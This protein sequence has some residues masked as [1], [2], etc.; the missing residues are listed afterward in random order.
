MLISN[1]NRNSS[2]NSFIS[3]SDVL[4]VQARDAIKSQHG[5][6]NFSP[7]VWK[8]IDK[9]FD[10]GSS[11]KMNLSDFNSEERDQYLKIIATL[12]KKGIIGWNY[13]EVNG[14]IEKHFTDTSIGDQR[15]ANAVPVKWKKPD[16]YY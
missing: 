2:V 11:Q 1:V 16:G 3:K 15:L 4:K 5:S 10:L 14:Q 13:Y 12:L 8:S 9:L 6:E 7:K